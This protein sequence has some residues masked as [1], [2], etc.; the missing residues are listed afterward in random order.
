MIA[1]AAPASPLVRGAAAVVAV[2]AWA[3]LGLRLD[4]SWAATGDL[5]WAI[6]GMLRFFTII[7]NLF[8][9]I[10]FSGIALGRPR[11]SHP[12]LLGAVTL[13]ILLVGIVFAA[14]LSGL[15]ILAGTAL[16]ADVVM[17]KVVPVLVPIYWLAFAPKGRLIAWDP[18]RWATVPLF[19]FVYVLARARIDGKYP[20][21]FF[22]VE[23]IGWGGVMAYALAMAA[24]FLLVGFALVWLDRRLGRGVSLQ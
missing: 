6:W 15:K 11:W 14:L 16:V 19:Y 21:F 1:G 5:S 7:A 23:R 18:V 20:Y 12:S 13:S 22:N 10:L 4:V 9:A 3:G 24:G 17:H 2:A 8:V